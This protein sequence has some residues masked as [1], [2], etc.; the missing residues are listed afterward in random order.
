M[1][2][3]SA[4]LD[5]SSGQIIFV[6]CNFFKSEIDATHDFLDQGPKHKGPKGLFLLGTTLYI[7]FICLEV[8]NASY[9]F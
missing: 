4:I 5:R 8:D 1:T 3:L 6:D 7:E 9:L 2:N